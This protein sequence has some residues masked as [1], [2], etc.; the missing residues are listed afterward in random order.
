MQSLTRYARRV[1]D[2]N[3][4]SAAACGSDPSVLLR[5]HTGGVIGSRLGE[6]GSTGIAIFA[7]DLK[8]AMERGLSAS[9]LVCAIL[10]AFVMMAGLA[11]DGAA[12]LA[13]QRRAEV[14]AAQAARVG[15]DTAAA[16]RLVGQ[17]GTAAALEAARRQVINQSGM[18]VEAHLDGN[19]QLVVTTSTSVRTVFLSIL[20]VDT[21]PA[22]GRA[23]AQLGPA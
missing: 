16:Y 15:C 19:K 13:A 20:G 11:V 12:Q 8:R 22:Q 21:L 10:P 1:K 9:V 5:W 7:G 4:R 3:A 23:V 17:Q 18:S 2:L 6:V 14:I